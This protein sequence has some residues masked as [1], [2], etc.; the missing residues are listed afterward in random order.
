MDGAEFPLFWFFGLRGPSTGA[1]G[2][3]V[4]LMVDFGRAHAKE[5]FP[6][7]LLPVS[8]PHGEPQPSTPA[9]AGDPPTLAGRSVQSPVGSLLLPPGS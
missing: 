9:S 3:L 2:S 8:C 5:Y 1:R 6:E 4:G 7:L